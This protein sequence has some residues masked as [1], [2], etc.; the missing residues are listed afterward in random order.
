MQVKIHD[1]GIQYFDNAT[2]KTTKSMYTMAKLERYEDVVYLCDE[3]ITE[4]QQAHY[5]FCK[6]EEKIPE[7]DYKTQETINE[8]KKECEVHIDTIEEVKS[9]TYELIYEKKTEEERREILKD[10]FDFISSLFV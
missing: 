3:A 2:T 5:Y 4:Y 7:E 8:W 9:T 6:A 1:K 10:I